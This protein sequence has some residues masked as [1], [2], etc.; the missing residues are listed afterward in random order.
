M[1]QHSYPGT[2]PVAS[3]MCVWVTIAGAGVYGLPIRTLAEL[4]SL[5]GVLIIYK[6]RTQKIIFSVI[7]KITQAEN[8]V[9][10]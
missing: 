1:Q 4:V 8:N 2:Q 7:K 3:A 9:D 6:V 10:C 5:C